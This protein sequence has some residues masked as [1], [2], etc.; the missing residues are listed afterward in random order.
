MRTLLVFTLLFAPATV[1]ADCTNDIAALGA[2]YEI[3]QLSLR[4]YGSSYE[5]GRAVERHIDLLREPLGNGRYRWVRY[6][7]PTGDAPV[8]KREHLVSV[9]QEKGDLSSFEAAG[10]HPFAVK[11]SVPR[12]RSTFKGNNEVYAGKLLVRYWVDG[13][14][15]TLERTIDQW[16]APDTSKSF[17]LD[18]IADRA[19]A[20]LEVA[21]RSAK[22]NESLVE[23]HFKQ[24]VAQDDPANP[25]IDAIRALER[26][27]QYSDPE[28]IDDEV[29][30][31]ERRLFPSLDPFPFAWITAQV[32]EANRL[33]KSEKV[34]EK[35][36][37]RVLLEEA[38]RKLP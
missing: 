25:S 16:M 11:V 29:R 37:G 20:T 24:A 1:F 5:I 10:E 31:L 18:A 2:L 22:R 8:V 35:E 3:R 12:K 34:E 30:K 7:R 19:E 21:A 27:A 14:M 28:T 6:V 17:D 13:K 32:R 4:S 26:V 36:K 33:M 38:V 23:I 15:K 9:A